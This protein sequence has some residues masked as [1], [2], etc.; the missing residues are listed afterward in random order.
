MEK[1]E[2]LE[3][4]KTEKELKQ[5]E[6]FGLTTDRIREEFEEARNK[7]IYLMGILSDAQETII[8]EYKMQY[9]N[10]AKYIIDQ[11]M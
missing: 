3:N 8:E 4:I 9:L 11:L 7:K 5:I 1:L 10:K 2:K 6:M